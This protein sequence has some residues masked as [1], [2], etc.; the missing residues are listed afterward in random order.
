LTLGHVHFLIRL[1]RRRLTRIN[2]RCL[3]FLGSIRGFLP[4]EVPGADSDEEYQRRATS[5][6]PRPETPGMIAPRRRMHRHY[7]DIS[8][9]R[10]ADALARMSRLG[11]AGFATCRA[12]ESEE[13]VHKSLLQSN[14]LGCHSAIGRRRS[15]INR[16]TVLKRDVE[17]G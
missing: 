10:T 1:S 6:Q 16:R 15:K 2:N 5:K 3:P 8:A 11:P 4:G 13:I 9:R 14:A 7:D 12:L 17:F